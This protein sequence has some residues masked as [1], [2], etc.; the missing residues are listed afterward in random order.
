MEDWAM[1]FEAVFGGFVKASP[2]RV[3]NRMLFERMF[4]ASR[5]D[6][7]FQNVGER[8][9]THELRCSTVVDIKSLVV[10]RSRSLVNAVYRDQKEAVGVHY[11]G[12]D[13]EV[14]ARRITVT[15]DTPTR[16]GETEIP[17]T[18]NLSA[19]AADALTVA[20]LHRHRW[21]L[22]TAF[23]ATTVD[24]KCEI[25]TLG[26]PQARCS[27]SAWPLSKNHGLCDNGL[28]D[29]P[30]AYPD[31]A[32]WSSPRESIDGE[33]VTG[34]SFFRSVAAADWRSASSRCD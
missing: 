27:D 23:Q 26:Y 3:M 16:D 5:L 20:A 2:V 15:L 7:R 1:L 18:T 33:G 11:P 29:V 28:G 31:D 4:A 34:V 13:A 6:D 10:M 9:Y 14:V 8:Q 25:D 24:L 12:T 32:G 22:E 19:K 21:Q 30:W 17:L